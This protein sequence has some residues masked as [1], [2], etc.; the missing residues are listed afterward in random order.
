MYYRT[1]VQNQRVSPS[2]IHTE[3]TLTTSLL[4]TNCITEKYTYIKSMLL[5]RHHGVGKVQESTVKYSRN[6]YKKRKNRKPSIEIVL[7]WKATRTWQIPSPLIVVGPWQLRTSLVCFNHHFRRFFSNLTLPPAWVGDGQAL[8]LLF[9]PVFWWSN[10]SRFRIYFVSNNLTTLC[11]KSC[12]VF[13]HL[14][15]CVVVACSGVH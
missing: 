11:H 10:N 5:L 15:W 13:L 3:R 7:K 6:L 12:L 2:I 4:A 9:L 14:K 1:K 8:K